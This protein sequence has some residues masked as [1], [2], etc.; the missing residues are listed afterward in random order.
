MPDDRRD[1]RGPLRVLVF[2]SLYPNAAM[3]SFGI[4]VENRLR[5]LVATGQV[6]ARV[7]APVPWFPSRHPR[8]G[9]YARWASVPA[10]E[11]RHGISIRH[12]RYP[13]PPKI[14]MLA[15]PFLMAAG[16]LATLR[17]LKFDF[18]VIDAHYFY[19]DGVAAVLLGAW[20]DRPVVITARG[21][22]LNVYPRQSARVRRLMV[23]A[24]RRASASIAVSNT[25]AG[26]LVGIGAP[27]ERVSVLRN[28]VDLDLF[29]PPDHS[30][31]RQS[32]GLRSP[33]ILS[34]GNLIPLKGHDLVIEALRQ[35]PEHRLVIVGE[36]PERASLEQLADRLS[37]SSRVTF[38]GSLAHDRLPAVYGVADVLVLASEREGWPNV[39]LEA[40]ACG[41]PVVATN[42]GGIPEIV[43]SHDAGRILSERS[44]AAIAAAVTAL[45]ADPPSRAAVRRHAEGFSW[46]ATTQGQLRVFRSALGRQDS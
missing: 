5:H 17:R 46:D 10:E 27:E 34:V 15:H 18:D 8:F 33:V 29:R 43:S 41:T 16:A 24:A 32:R 26:L 11:A 31:A 20:F 1:D 2:S 38:L 12:P 40:L 30:S 22:D 45:G 28:G 14:G 3:P 36:G 25:L 4:F 35:L 9:A 13:L 7:M 6:D 21:T 19:P 44:P 42:V 23:W 37:V 39:L